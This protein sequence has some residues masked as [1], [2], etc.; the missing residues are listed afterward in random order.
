[1]DSPVVKTSKGAVRG[2][3]D[4]AVEVF[5]GVPYAGTTAGANRFR[6]PVPR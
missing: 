6:P 5:K 2:T 3:V 4:E 1:M